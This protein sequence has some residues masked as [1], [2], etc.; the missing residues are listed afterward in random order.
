MSPSDWLHAGVEPGQP[1][2]DFMLAVDKVIDLLEYTLKPELYA[3]A[4]RLIADA[5]AAA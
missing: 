4:R 1:T 2:P 3:T 5:E